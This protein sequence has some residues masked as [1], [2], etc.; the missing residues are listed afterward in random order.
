MTHCSLISC[1][2]NLPIRSSHG[3]HKNR[4][5]TDLIPSSGLWGGAKHYCS[6]WS[7]FAWS[8]SGDTEVQEWYSRC[9]RGS[10]EEEG[11]EAR[12][13]VSNQQ[14]LFIAYLQSH[15]VPIKTD[16]QPWS[17]S[18][19]QPIVGAVCSPCS[20]TYLS[21]ESSLHFR[22]LTNGSSKS[23][24]NEFFHKAFFG[25]LY[26]R[27]FNFGAWPYKAYALIYILAQHTLV[28]QI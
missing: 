26:V 22:L 16:S 13:W 21:G 2:T 12:P 19:S 9:F 4:S 7:N 25:T 28:A 18:M 14:S 27:E 23:H 6:P 24:K 20:V 5:S 10:S 11:S 15:S 3:P 8:R 17:K 1:L